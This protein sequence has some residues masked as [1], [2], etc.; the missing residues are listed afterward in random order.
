MTFQE[1][2]LSP[3]L[4]Q[5]AAPPKVRWNLFMRIVG[6]DQSCVTKMV[7]SISFYDPSRKIKVSLSGSSFS[8]NRMY[9]ILTTTDPNLE[10]P[11][12]ISWK[13]MKLDIDFEVRESPLPTKLIL[14]S[15]GVSKTQ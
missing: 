10:I 12:E 4:T 5:K 15:K 1:G 11:I 3:T 8:A 2:V 6:K 14:S 13:P 9:T 7:E